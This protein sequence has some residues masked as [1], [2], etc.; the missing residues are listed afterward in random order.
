MEDNRNSRKAGVAKGNGARKV[1]QGKRMQ[2]SRPDRAMEN[3]TKRQAASS[4]GRPPQGKKRSV[5]AGRPTQ[6]KKR[7]AQAGRPVKGGKAP[8]TPQQMQR[9]KRNKILLF[10]AEIFVLLILLVAFWG[11]DKVRKINIVT[12]EEEE[13]EINEE[14]QEYA[15]TGLMKGYRNIAIFGVDS[16]EKQLD[17]ATRTD[18]IIVASINEDS[19]EVKLV[20]LYRDTFLNLSTDTYNKANLAYSKGG[21]KQAIAMLNMNLDL[22]ITDFVTILSLI[23]I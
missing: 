22:N 4:A 18:V 7:P 10:V 20:S 8:L 14:V 15:E 2:G 13:V 16:R 19:G 23:H 5:Q 6:G 21:P 12:I 11:A 17:K 9:K 3:G 1:T